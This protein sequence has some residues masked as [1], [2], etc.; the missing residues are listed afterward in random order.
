MHLK[1]LR[2][3]VKGK[4]SEGT[5]VETDVAFGTEQ[6]DIPSI[7][8]AAKKAGIMRYYTEDESQ[9]YHKQVSQTMLY[10]KNLSI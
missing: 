1:D 2:K 8:K 6:L 9:S 7:L 5:A 3:G 4:L 10:L